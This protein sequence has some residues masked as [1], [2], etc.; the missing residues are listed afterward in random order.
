MS[1]DEKDAIGANDSSSQNGEQI[2][3]TM[4]ADELRLAQMGS[5]NLQEQ[6]KALACTN[7]SQDISRNLLAISIF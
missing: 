7:P 6:K 2:K 5:F 3:P 4:D 1:S